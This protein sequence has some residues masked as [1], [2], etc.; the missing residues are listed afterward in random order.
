MGERRE[1]EPIPRTVKRK[2]KPRPRKKRKATVADCDKEFGLLIRGPKGAEYPCL[3][4]GKRDN[5]QC[6]HGF[7]RSYHAIRWDDR[8]AF[9]LCRG[10]HVFYTHRP[11]Q[12]D[13]W[14]REKWG[15]GL[16]DELRMLALSHARVDKDALLADLKAR[17]GGIE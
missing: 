2:P 13:D 1:V 15:P 3:V 8:N 12:W 17:T 16:Y 4:C 14:L 10:C 7:T 9:P 11:I 6:A 5:I